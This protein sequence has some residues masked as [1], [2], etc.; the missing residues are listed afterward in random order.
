M[1]NHDV[2]N[3]E[4]EGVGTLWVLDPFSEVKMRAVWEADRRWERNRAEPRLSLQRRGDG[5]RV[6]AS[7]WGWSSFLQWPHLNSPLSWSTVSLGPWG[8]CWTRKRTSFLLRASTWLWEQPEAYTGTMWV[9]SCQAEQS[10]SAP[11]PDSPRDGERTGQKPQVV[12][13]SLS[14]VVT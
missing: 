6:R 4:E 9:E 3:D 7:Q 5:C 13:A 11:A 8:S 12:S 10:E 14:C 2:P 1:Y